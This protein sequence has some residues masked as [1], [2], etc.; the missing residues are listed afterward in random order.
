[1][2]S[3]ADQIIHKNDMSGAL[4]SAGNFK[5]LSRANVSWHHFDR[6]YFFFESELDVPSVSDEKSYA[7]LKREHIRHLVP[8]RGGYYDYIAHHEY[9]TLKDWAR[10]NGK[11]TDDI[12]YG[13]IKKHRNNASNPI[14]AYVSLYTLVKHLDPSYEGEVTVDIP[15]VSDKEKLL[16]EFDDIIQQITRLRE[17]IGFIL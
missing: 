4:V 2:Q 8:Y 1:M 17:K 16:A 13:I 15:E 3:I 10:D 6:L 5:T 14:V 9:A 11:S 12:C 7:S